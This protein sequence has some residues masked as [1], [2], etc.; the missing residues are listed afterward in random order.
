MEKHVQGDKRKKTVEEGFRLTRNLGWVERAIRV[1]LALVL[2]QI[3]S[4]ETT[5]AGQAAAAFAVGVFLFI[6]AITGRC[7]TWKIFGWDDQ[8]S[9]DDVSK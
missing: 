8:Q 1:L 7:V 4:M 2:L 5:P 9:R 3:G 6:T